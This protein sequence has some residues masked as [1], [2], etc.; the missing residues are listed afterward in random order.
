MHKEVQGHPE[1]K[2][3]DCVDPTTGEHFVDHLW[4]IIQPGVE[5]IV[6][7]GDDFDLKHSQ[8]QVSQTQSGRG[9]HKCKRGSGGSGGGN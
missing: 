2:E 3:L 4:R 7:N 1:Y 5:Y 8:P 6:K 9:N